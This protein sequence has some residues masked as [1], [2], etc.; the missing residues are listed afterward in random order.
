MSFAQPGETDAVA[1][2]IL[3]PEQLD[4][5]FFAF[6]AKCW[7]KLWEDAARNTLE[8]RTF[9]REARRRL[10]KSVRPKPERLL[11]SI[12]VKNEPNR[13]LKTK[14]LSPP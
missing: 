9:L 13:L 2:S 3:S 4:H 1:A 12:R 8:H 6:R 5:P 10:L 14:E 7:R 11:K